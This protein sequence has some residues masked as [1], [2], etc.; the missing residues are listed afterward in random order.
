MASPQLR[1]YGVQAIPVL[2]LLLLLLLLPLRVTPGTT[3]PPP[4]SIEHADIR[5]KNYSVNSRE[6]ARSFLSQIRYRNDHRDSY[7]AWLQA[8]TIPNNFCRN[9]RDR[10][11]QVL[12][13]P[14]SCSN[15][16]LGAYS[17]H[18]PQDNRDF[19]PQFQNDES[20]HLYIGPLGWCRGCDGFP[21]LV[22]Q[23]KAAFSAVPC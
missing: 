12:P 6:R 23:I 15:N 7:Y 1:G 19:S 10:Q 2:L 4:V 16:D 5:V 13:S 8:D 3:C 9:Y 21:G 17:L 11:S 22:H 14:I 20:G 18:L